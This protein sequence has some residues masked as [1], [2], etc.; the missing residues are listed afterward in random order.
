MIL[1]FFN[2]GRGLGFTSSNDDHLS[3]TFTFGSDAGNARAWMI[4]LA[5]TH[6][7]EQRMKITATILSLLFALLLLSGLSSCAKVG[8]E[9]WCKKMEEKSA[10][11]WT[12]TEAKD[13]AKHCL[14]K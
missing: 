7:E 6:L 1:I 11:D 12:A 9:R 8:S 2:L 3:L 14:I 10:G 4:L 5:D 13:Y